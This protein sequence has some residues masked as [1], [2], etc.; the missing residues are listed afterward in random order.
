MAGR[1]YQTSHSLRRASVQ[2][3]GD[4]RGDS[5]SPLRTVAVEPSENSRLCPPNQRPVTWA[6]AANFTRALM[7][8][9]SANCCASVVIAFSPIDA[10]APR[11]L[12]YRT[13]SRVRQPIITHCYISPGPGPPSPDLLL[14]RHIHARTPR[15]ACRQ[16]GVVGRVCLWAFHPHSPRPVFPQFPCESESRVVGSLTGRKK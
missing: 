3:I 10:A 12:N 2:S 6:E 11:D 16:V 15:G 13:P 7:S 8:R 5:T 9:M 4:G 1:L 14:P